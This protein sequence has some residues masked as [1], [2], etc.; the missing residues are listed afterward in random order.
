VFLY[1]RLVLKS[2]NQCASCVSLEGSVIY[3]HRAFIG[4]YGSGQTDGLT[5]TQTDMTKL[6]VAFRNFANAPKNV[7]CEVRTEVSSIIYSTKSEVSN[8]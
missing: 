3:T 4:F 2:S 7:S 6:I 5:D 8:N 1:T